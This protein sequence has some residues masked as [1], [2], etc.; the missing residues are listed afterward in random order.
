MT[1]NKIRVLCIVM[2]LTMAVLGAVAFADGTQQARETAQE[3]SKTIQVRQI[4]QERNAEGDLIAFTQNKKILPAVYSS[5]SFPVAEDEQGFWRDI[6]ENVIDKYVTVANTGEQNVY[7]RTTIAIEADEEGYSGGS[8]IKFNINTDNYD[9]LYGIEE[10]AKYGDIG[11]IENVEINC[12]YDS[13]GD[14]V[15]DSIIKDR[16]DILTGVYRAQ[17]N[18]GSVSEP[19]LLQIAMDKKAEGIYVDQF[20]DTFEILVHTQ[21][22]QVPPEGA[23]MTVIE[24]FGGEITSTNHPWKTNTNN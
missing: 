12:P 7:F 9:W 20:G 18:V 11:I 24:A 15:N 3:T 8:L 5:D 13:D 22:V 6:T 4:E 17:L 14:N 19:S 2:V 10:T 16:Y 1:K 23:E 21:A